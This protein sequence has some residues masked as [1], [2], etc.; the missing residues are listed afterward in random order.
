M[1]VTLTPPTELP[2]SLEDARAWLRVT[3]NDDDKTIEDLIK[4]A[5]E[6][7]ED[8]T[9]RALLNTEYRWQ[10]YRWPD[11]RTQSNIG[12]GQKT[13]PFSVKYPLYFVVLPRC[14]VVSVK[15]VKYLS[16][17]GA[18]VEISPSQYSI[19]SSTSP[20]LLVFSKA[21]PAPSSPVPRP[22]AVQ[23]VFT[24]GYG[25][26]AS[27]VNHR[28]RMVIKYMVANA[29]ENRTPV[30]TGTIATALPYSMQTILRQMKVDNPYIQ[31][32]TLA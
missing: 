23:I 1:F 21:P 3:N 30:V 7:I 31:T 27:D 32:G 19:D 2:L 24:A 12:A 6:T 29:Y 10:D 9:G 16:E 17:S 8:Y 20:G 15:S 18:F 13:P 5:C 28:L 11:F 14:P 25:D 26:E 22:D 4:S